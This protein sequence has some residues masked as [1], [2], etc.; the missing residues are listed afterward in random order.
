MENITLKNDPAM[1]NAADAFDKPVLRCHKCSSTFH[2]RIPR[3]WFLKYV[4]FFLPIKVYFCGRCV[5][6]RYIL[7]TDKSEA[8]YQPV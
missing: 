2:Y 4:L 1:Y 6:F 3:G 5:K 7:L 8:K